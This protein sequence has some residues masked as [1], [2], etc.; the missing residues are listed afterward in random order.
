MVNFEDLQS[1]WDEI[2][3]FDDS[4]LADVANLVSETHRSLKS[5]LDNRD[6]VELIVAALMVPVFCY[7]AWS[8]PNVYVR[9]G[10]L[11]IVAGMF[12]IAGFLLWGR[13]GIAVT[14]DQLSVREFT[15]HQRTLVRRQIFLLR[16]IAWWYLAPIYVGLMVM[17]YGA[18]SGSYLIFYGGIVTLL[19]AAIWRANQKAVASQL[20]PL[21]DEYTVALGLI[22]HP[23]QHTFNESIAPS[24]IIKAQHPIAYVLKVAALLF[25]VGMLVVLVGW[26]HDALSDS[27]S[28]P[29]LAPFSAVRWGK[30]SSSRSGQ[31]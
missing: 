26:I 31:R 7:F 4:Q 2:E 3:G 14:P 19:F 11:I 6:V 5:V 24:R 28:Y 18:G 9:I 27:R 16:N 13:R 15:L 17:T 23:E 20:Q 10:A 25:L 22:D 30:R 12:V 21:D 8:A 1:G 29:K